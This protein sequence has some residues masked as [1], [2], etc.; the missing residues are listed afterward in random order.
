MICSKHTC[1]VKGVDHDK[2][3]RTVVEGV[4]HKS[5]HILVEGVDHDQSKHLVVGVDLDQQL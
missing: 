2:S 3:K 5:K 4:D 1:I